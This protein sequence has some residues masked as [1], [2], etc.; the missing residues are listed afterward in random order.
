MKLYSGVIEPMDDRIL[1]IHT[2]RDR[3]FVDFKQDDAAGWDHNPDA[4]T[5]RTWVVALPDD[6]EVSEGELSRAEWDELFILE[7]PSFV[8]AL[9]SVRES[10]CT[11]TSHGIS[12]GVCCP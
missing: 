11:C 8:K 2:G 5:F 6:A 4:D 1:R 10:W 12:H 3:G 9:G 7:S